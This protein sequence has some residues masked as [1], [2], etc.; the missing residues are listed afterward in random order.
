MSADPQGDEQA[1]ANPLPLF[2]RAPE[3]LTAHRHGDWRLHD[4]D[5]SFAAETPFV[6]IVAGEI[7]A[8]ARDYPVVFAAGGAQPIAVLGVEYENLFVE[9]G[10]WIPDAY[11]PAYVRRYPFGFIRTV[12]PDGFA[13]AIDTGADRVTREGEDGAALFDADGPTAL[14]RQAMRFCEA[15]EGEA[16][17][18]SA[19]VGALVAADLLVDRRADVTLP[20]GRKLG[21]DGFGIVDAERFAALPGETIL[22]WH[23]KGWLGLI[24]LHLSS[25]ERFPALLARRASRNEASAS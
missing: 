21:L 5:L 19:F 13:L 7:A 2:Y 6:P 11:V 23:R 16:A 9:D 8:A 1:V 4:G 14:T 22:D 18:T 3:P 15:F 10:R 12:N 20:D 17:A 24:H 25:L